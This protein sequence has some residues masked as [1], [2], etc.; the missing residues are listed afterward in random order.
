M[1]APTRGY[2]HAET[3]FQIEL[4]RL[5]FLETRYD[6]VT[7]G[8]LRVAQP[9]EGLR[10]LEVGAGAGS[11]ARMLAESVGPTGH[12][13]ALD[14]DPR[15]LGDLTLPNVTVRQHNIVTDELEQSEYDLVHC[16]ALLLHLADPMTAL[17]RM[18]AALRPG[19]LLLVEDTDFSSLAAVAGHASSAEFNRLIRLCREGDLDGRAFDPR[20]GGELPGLLAGLGLVERGDEA[21]RLERTGGS[22][23]AEVMAIALEAVDGAALSL[24]LP[25]GTDLAP[26]IAAFRDPTFCY[27]DSLNV[28]AWGRRP[29]PGYLG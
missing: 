23:E 20:L 19:G 22:P 21:L 11:V 13:V 25:A 7:R 12:V 8:R 27:V 4:E 5:R 24:G 16:R 28:G 29:M 26:M 10:C 3:P 1:S 17:D 2:M 6:G 14:L 18:V 15:F 9:F